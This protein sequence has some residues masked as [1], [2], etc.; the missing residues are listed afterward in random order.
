MSKFYGQV[1]GSASTIASRRGFDKIKV[2][3]QS[4]DGSLITRMYYRKDVLTVDLEV[5][6]GSSMHG[7]TIY[8]GSLDNLIKKLGGTK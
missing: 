4:W 2:S 3:A 5:S 7:H 1:A 8:S 6:E